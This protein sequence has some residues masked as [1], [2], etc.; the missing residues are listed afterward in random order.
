D[1]KII[2]TKKGE[3]VCGSKEIS[4][5]STENILRNEVPKLIKALDFPKTMRWNNSG[6]RFPRPV[7][8]ILALLDRKPLRF[9][10]AGIEADRYSM[11][12]LH[13]SFK[14]I[15]LEKPREYLNFLRHGGVI[16]DPN[17]RYRLIVKRIKEASRDFEGK[18]FLQEEMIEAINCVVEYPEGVA[19]EFDRKYLDL[20]EEVMLSVF[21]T[22]GNLIWIKPLNKFV[23]IFSARK[24]AFENVARGFT[25][26]IAARLYDAH[27]YYQNDIKTGIEK[28][29]EQT[30]GMMWLQDL[31]SI[32][33]KTERLSKLVQIFEGM[34]SVDT[35]KLQRAARLCKA[36]LLSQMV[37]EKD[38]TALQGIMGGYYAQIAGEDAR[39]TQAIEEHYLPKFV[40]DAMPSTL[41]GCLLSAVDKFDNV[42][43]AFLSG[44]RPTGS[45]DPL[46][47]RRNGYAVINL[48]DTYAGN[49]N[50]LDAVKTLQEIYNREFDRAMIIDFFSER[51]DRY[52]ED[53][54]FRYDEVN[55]VLAT[56]NG[57]VGDARLRCEALRD[58][59]DKPEFTKLVIG[60][61]RVRNILKGIENIGKLDIDL[62]KEKSEINLY[63]E[64][65]A[66]I[67][68]IK[69]LLEQKNYKGVLK[70]LLSLRP[71]I[72]K[73]FDDVMVMCDDEKIKAN[74]L[75]LLHYVNQIFLK[76][77]DFSCIVIEGEKQEKS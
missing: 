54:G 19:G 34:N 61:K 15:R 32:Y 28:M 30:R 13:F 35:G 12:N 56:W 52:L 7:R 2:K 57:I 41:E 38:F 25:G 75:A 66:I 64:S 8:W 24:K 10:F 31:G 74:R 18:P 71:H 21:K 20:P 73:F 48:F 42:I 27:F 36:D 77:A 17:E 46:G 70:I 45:Y 29:R 22:Q 26:V 37:R 53:L 67:Q 72:D 5:E 9:K 62:L 39:V 47:V 40:G 11:P 60:Q 23:C 33:D 55:T 63:N 58:L 6:D 76:F 14:P 4:G 68:D 16:A 44:N 51:L 50:L 59:S 3:Y 1:I 43:G 49:T 65:S 69:A